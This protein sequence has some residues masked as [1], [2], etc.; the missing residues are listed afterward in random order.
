[1]KAKLGNLMRSVHNTMNTVAA[2]SAKMYKFGLSKNKTF[3][4]V[5]ITVNDVPRGNI[6]GGNVSSTMGKKE[7]FVVG[8]EDNDITAYACKAGFLAC[9]PDRQPEEFKEHHET[10]VLATPKAARE[11]VDD[12]RAKREKGAA[13]NA[14]MTLPEAVQSLPDKNEIISRLLGIS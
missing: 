11:Y 9:Y 13:K 12:Y 14:M 2:L 6:N 8:V 10:L 5:L 4:Q 3:Y 7:V 1:M